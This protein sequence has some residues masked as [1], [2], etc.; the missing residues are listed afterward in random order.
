MI[1]YTVKSQGYVEIVNFTKHQRIDRPSPSGL[2]E[3]SSADSTNDPRAPVEPL[4]GPSPLDKE[5]DQGEGGD[6]DQLSA[7]SLPR[8]AS[9]DEQTIFEEWVKVT[10]RDPARTKLTPERRRTIAKAVKLASGGTAECL[11]AVR[12]LGASRWAA[13]ENDRA[14]PFN[15]IKHALG[16]IE[17]IEEWARRWREGGAA[18][19][20]RL[21]EA[22]GGSRSPAAVAG[23]IVAELGLAGAPDSLK[24]VDQG[25]RFGG[26]TDAASARAFLAQAWPQLAAL[27]VEAA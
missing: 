5:K 13:G 25:V 15:D 20:V 6:Q 11:D 18:G 9:G 24:A 17:R 23:T 10:S 21:A 8:A 2:P 27:I 7:A 14:R 22:G 26:V 12:G 16:N 4:G 1:A 3:P 19:A